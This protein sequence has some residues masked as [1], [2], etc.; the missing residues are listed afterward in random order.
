[1]TANTS[2]LLRSLALEARTLEKKTEEEGKEVIVKKAAKKTAPTFAITLYEYPDIIVTKTTS[3]AVKHLIMMPTAK[4]VFF[5]E[6]KK[7]EVKTIPFTPEEYSS[8]TRGMEDIQMPEDF[9]GKR[10]QKGIA[11]YF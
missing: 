7:G 6:E 3:T 10:L 2:D 11:I 5:K 1:M 9:W 4:S 8:F